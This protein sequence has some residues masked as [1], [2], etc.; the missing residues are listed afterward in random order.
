VSSC[1]SGTVLCQHPCHSS[2]QGTYKYLLSYVVHSLCSGLDHPRSN[3]GSF[4]F[5]CMSSG[6]SGTVFCQPPCHSRYITIFIVSCC[7]CAFVYMKSA[8]A[9]ALCSGL[10]HPRSGSFRIICVNRQIW[11]CLMSTSM[12]FKVYTNIYYQLLR[13]RFCLH[14]VSCCACAPDWTIRDPTLAHSGLYACRLANLELSC[15]NLE[16]T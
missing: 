11:N 10:D 16:G 7:G 8:V 2:L 12:S 9:R 6:K 4:R 1:K 13:V 3:Y 5:I 14:E 15:V